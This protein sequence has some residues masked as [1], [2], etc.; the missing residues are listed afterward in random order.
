MGAARANCTIS[1]RVQPDGSR[2][3]GKAER[4]PSS[5]NDRGVGASLLMR[6]ATGRAATAQFTV[7]LTLAINGNVACGPNCLITSSAINTS[8]GQS[9]VS[10]ITKSM[11]SSTAQPDLLGVHEPHTLARGPVVWVIAPGVARVAGHKHAAPCC[12]AP[13]SVTAC[14]IIAS[15][16]FLTA[17]VEIAR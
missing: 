8:P 11:P 17:Y 16:S 3:D 14:R 7:S 13:A 10:E 4:S 12:Y 1:Q 9:L 5:V 6:N 15:S 2:P